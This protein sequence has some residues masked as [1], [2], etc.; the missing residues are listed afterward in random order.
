MPGLLHPPPA[1]AR[2]SPTWRPAILAHLL[3][4]A[5]SRLPLDTSASSTITLPPP[6]IRA[7][8]HQP[9]APK[10]EPH[11]SWPWS[12]LLATLTPAWGG[13]GERRPSG[14]DRKRMKAQKGGLEKA[15][16]P[17]SGVPAAL[18]APESGVLS[19]SHGRITGDSVLQVK[20]SG[21]QTECRL[22][23]TVLKGEAGGCVQTCL[24]MVCGPSSVLLESVCSCFVEDFC[25]YA[26]Q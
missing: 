24:I 26:H 25:I 20:P 4:M 3:E 17:G 13:G 16:L 21:P 23:L 10:R 5:S 6:G 11:Q 7:L 19:A 1:C 18:S 22:G 8:C 12:L 14:G 15:P 2:T 9:P